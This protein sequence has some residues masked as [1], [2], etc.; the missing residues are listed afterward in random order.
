MSVG[1]NGWGHWRVGCRVAAASLAVRRWLP[2]V[3]AT[4]LAIAG[5]ASN[6][7]APVIERAAAKKPAHRSSLSA[8][9]W[10]P[11]TY[12]VQK[13]E[14]LYGIAFDHGFDYRELAQWNE[15][16]PPYVIKVGQQLRLTPPQQTV[17]TTP[18]KQLAPVEIAR[19]DN[20][21]LLKTEPKAVKLPYAEQGTGEKPI[22]AEQPQARPPVAERKEPPKETPPE[23]KDEATAGAEDDNGLEWAWPTPGKVVAGFKEGSSAK[24][25]DIAGKSGQPVY[26]AAPGKVVYSGS[27]LRG[28]GKL[29][30]IKHNKT[31]LSAYAHNSLILV[32]EGQN[33]ARGQKIAEMGDSDADQVKL[34]FEVRRLGKPVDP[35]KYLPSERT[36]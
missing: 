1:R 13:G 15:I 35:M 5:C 2:P 25:L 24:G 8:S 17:V 23:S 34:H 4:V 26:A 27:G 16:G 9:D 19:A 21:S 18:L 33:V 32:K 6:R 3:L 30:I 28:Y 10:R 22:K 36:S 29:V 31:Y 7:S 12:Q 11:Q 20:S 14:T